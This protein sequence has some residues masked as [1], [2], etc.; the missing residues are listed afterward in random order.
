MPRQRIARRRLTRRRRFSSE[1]LARIR[2]STRWRLTSASLERS[3]KLW[4]LWISRQSVIAALG[5]S[6]WP[7]VR[8][9]CDVKWRGLDTYLR[10]LNFL[11][12]VVDRICEIHFHTIKNKKV[13]CKKAQPKETVTPATQLQLQKRLLLSGLG[14]RMPTGMVAAPGSAGVPNPMAAYNPMAQVSIT[15]NSSDLQIFMKKAYGFQ[16]QANAAA[17][18]MVQ[19]QLAAAQPGASAVNGGKLYA[20]YPPSFHALR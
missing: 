13:E 1:A 10:I 17:N 2:R 20:T 18:Q 15:R 3:R 16:V 12:D 9:F 5:L 8:F 11:E 4:C 14:L 7:M 19:H 6:V